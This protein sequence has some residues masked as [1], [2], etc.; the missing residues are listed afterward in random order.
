MVFVG[1]GYQFPSTVMEAASTHIAF[2][3]QKRAGVAAWVAEHRRRLSRFVGHAA[4]RTDDRWNKALLLCELAG[5]H[6]CDYRPQLRW[7]KAVDKFWLV[8]GLLAGG[9]MTQVQNREE[10][11]RLEEEFINL[12]P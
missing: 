1:H 4:R 2:E 3:V 8:R 6:R 9:W 12:R 10:R 11:Q 5:V 7:S